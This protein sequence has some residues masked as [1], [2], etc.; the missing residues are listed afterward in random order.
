MWKSKSTKFIE[1][2]P[3]GSLYISSNKKT[4]QYYWKKDKGDRHGKYIQKKNEKLIK[5]LAQKEYEQEVLK[6][7]L[8]N[9]ILLEKIIDNYF[10]D[11]LID[12]YE[13]FPEQK[14]KLIDAYILPDEQFTEQWE[15]KQE[16]MKNKL[17]C[18]VSSKYNMSENKIM[19]EKNEWVRSKSEKIIADKLYKKD[20]PYI[21]EQPLLINGYGYVLPDFKV[22]NVKQR[23]EYYWEHLGMMENVEYT[24]KAIKKIELYEKNG[25]FPGKNLILTFETQDRPIDVKLLDKIVEEYLV[26]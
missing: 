18:K 23:K 22:L 9:K 26:D 14:R 21:Y 25:I 19:T 8:K 2:A 1:E 3:S 5:T 17:M 24:K 11:E 13:N 16:Q 6:K 15:E 10:F 12:V 4:F 7:V 20:I